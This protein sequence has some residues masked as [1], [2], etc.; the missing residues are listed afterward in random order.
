MQKSVLADDLVF[1]F[2]LVGDTGVGKSS[3][4][5]KYCEDKFLLEHN[6]TVGVDFRSKI[7]QIDPKTS[8][9]VQIWDT[10]GQ[11]TFG[12]IVRSFYRDCAGIF[13]VYDVNSK[14][15]FRN[16]EN[17]L[18]EVRTHCENDP[19]YILMGNQV[20][21]NREREVTYEEGKRFMEDCALNYFFETSAANGQNIQNAFAEAI[22]LVY[23]QYMQD[24]AHQ[25]MPKRS[26][27]KK[28][29]GSKLSQI[30]T[31][32]RSGGCC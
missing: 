5:L 8:V 18:Q 6:V 2:I 12:T 24:K 20:D 11:E 23:L 4:L 9:K 19:I 26:L 15:S 32:P 22:K 10:A 3:I 1:K 14:E 28:S 31:Q 27:A 21:N 13:L 7:V 25:N 29:A 17:W 16:L 30:S